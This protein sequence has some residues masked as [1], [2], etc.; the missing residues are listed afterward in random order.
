MQQGG[1]SGRCIAMWSGPR[2]ISTAMMRAWENRSDT[3]VVDEPFYAHFLQVTGLDHPL[4]EEIIDS[5]E[6]DWR[7]VVQ[8]LTVK[9]DSGIF[10]QKHI[11]THWFEHFSSQWL[12]E[13]DH[14]FL[15]RE[16][17][18]VVASY[19]IKREGLTASDLGYAQQAA[20]FDLVS[21]RADKRPAVIDSRRFLADPETQ[22][23]TVCA[24]LGIEFEHRM[25]A[26]PAGARDSD[27]VWGRHWYDAVNR[28]TGFTPARSVVPELDYQQQQV[29]DTCQP[30][31]E[32]LRKFA[33]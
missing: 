4:R 21:K 13:L 5:G 16:P 6:T 10:Y 24:H 17:V 27:G 12:D 22:L 3:V 19:A 23:R 26:W 30:F 31:Y 18:P 28:S 33:L 2:N 25:L 20:L 29:A 14:V 9:P 32:A 7:T 15:I 1:M 8:R 11:T